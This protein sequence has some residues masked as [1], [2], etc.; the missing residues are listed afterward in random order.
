MLNVPRQFKV[1][2]LLI[3]V[4]VVCGVVRTAHAQCDAVWDTA[5]G[6][7]GPNST[8]WSLL[9]VNEASAVGPAVYVGGQ[10][11]AVGALTAKNIAAW[12]GSSWSALGTGAENGGVVYALAAK[13][14]LLYAGGAFGNMGGLA[15]TKRI[16]KW[17]GTAWSDV[18]GG[19]SDNNAGIRALVFLGDDLYAGG[20]LNEIGGI[21]AR[22]L[23]KWD[24][25]AWSALPGD[26]LGSTDVVEALAVFDDGSGNA[27]YVGG[28]FA[29]AGGDTNAA[30]IFRWDGLT[31]EPLGQGTNDD[32]EAIVAWNGDL[33]VGGHFNRVYQT[34]GTEVIA[35]KIARWD[36][37]TWHALG[38]GM[39]SIASYHV[40]ALASFDDG[41]GEALYAGGN[42]TTA[43][44]VAVTR[45][46][47]WDGLGWS[48]VGSAGLNG[49][50]YAL[51]A[52]TYDG[53]LYVGGTFTTSGTPSANRIVR[54]G[55]PLPLSPTNASADPAEIVE[56]GSSTLS[57]AATGDTVYWY[58]DGCGTTLVDNGNP[59]VVSPTET[60]TYYAR[61]FDGTCWSYTCDE[62]TVTVSCAPPT[63]TA[64]PTGGAFCTGHPHELCIEATGSGTLSYQWKRN[65]LSLIGATSSCYSASDPG[66][67]LCVVTD[68]CSPTDSATAVVTEASPAA[69]DFDG[70]GNTDLDD[71]EE[72]SGCLAGPGNGLAEGC[73]CVDV[74]GD[75]DN[76]LDD[77]AQF[78]A[79]FTG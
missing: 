27:L 47:M 4:G 52:F 67:Y 17:N 9:A 33:Y 29:D 77:F 2:I 46:A 34:D 57:V 73:E 13:D 56:G 59:I 44:G 38:D 6:N 75:G 63:I 49:Y 50:V 70:D 54:R 31:L 39:N 42:F 40:W 8:V 58:T 78:Q 65:S 12:D 45:L 60:T 11:S 53:G 74:D 20:Y 21:T 55:G 48:A 76:D 25:A 14:G 79:A 62:V 35:N 30:N 5:I 28:E 10:F 51:D 23:A 72:F 37:T 36:G 68:D 66:T 61:A 32:V 71:F 26:P 41:A 22:K 64:Q 69:G 15:N 1:A 7:S 43:G 16:A 19:M 3:A 24:G 18:G